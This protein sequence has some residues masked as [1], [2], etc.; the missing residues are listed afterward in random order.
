MI[1]TLSGSGGAEQGMVRE[2]ARFSSFDEQLV[3]TLFGGGPLEEVVRDAG[4]E[5]VDLGLD[6]SDSAWNW[7]I[8]ARRLRSLLEQFRPHVVQSSLTSSNLVAQL[9]ARRS[10]VP[11]VSTF[12]LSGDPRLMREFQPGAD[13]WR[14]ALVRRFAAIL[15]RQSHVR[16][17]ALTKDAMATNCQAMGVPTSNVSVIPRGVPQ[18]GNDE[19]RPTRGE[20]GLPEGVPVLLN[21]GRQTAQ[22]GHLDLIAMMR[23]LNE[24][25][26]VHL[27]IL[28]REGDGTGPLVDSIASAGLEHSVSVIPY[29]S[30]PFAYYQNSDVFVFSSHMEGLGTAVLEAMGSGLPIV[31]YDIPPVREI[32]G[33]RLGRLVPVGDVAALESAVAA[34]LDDPEAA[35]LVSAAARSHVQESY[36]IDVVARQVEELLVAN[37]GRGTE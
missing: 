30:D 13:T 4:I 17:R 14:A 9:A 2:I 6:S 11:V 15:G 27:V 1:N 36:S 8:G 5:H 29:T 34:V 10:R 16:F 12:T 19:R 23:S 31:A 24:A 25:R 20:L 33:D 22:K 28:G 37:A 3:V 7:V 35:Q 18:E 26:D 32:V 21:V